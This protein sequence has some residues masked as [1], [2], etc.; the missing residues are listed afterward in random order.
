MAIEFAFCGTVALCRVAALST[1]SLQENI[2]EHME[3]G[4]G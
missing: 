4:P 1:Y 3:I 2:H